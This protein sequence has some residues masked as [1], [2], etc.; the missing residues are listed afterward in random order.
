[1]RSG[2]LK[3]ALVLFVV[4]SALF[5]L[6]SIKREVHSHSERLQRAHHNDSIRGQGILQ[7]M[8][9]MEADISRLVGLLKKLESKE[10]EGE[11]KQERKMVRKL[12]PKS[13]LFSQW[14]DHLSEE[15]QEEAQTL[16]QRFGYNA[17]LSDRLP[18]SREIPDTRP[19]RC[20][21]RKYPEELPSLSVVLIYL[22]EALSI[23]KRA[24]RSI[25][26]KTPAR[27]LT[28][29]I[30]VDDHSSNEDL[31]QKLDDYISLIHEERPGLV[32]KVRHAELM[33]LLLHFE[34][35]EN[36]EIERDR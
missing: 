11:L 21:E 25:M 23:I 31:M 33:T 28:E 9:K 5:Y 27:L 30:L 32:K 16:F 19:P 2:R 7:R 14:G 8:S 17:F 12:H 6:G 10:Q 4:S 3:G 22:D 15:D 24:I 1:M 34:L 35:L 13:P 20:A 26:D 18:L 36:F 29:I